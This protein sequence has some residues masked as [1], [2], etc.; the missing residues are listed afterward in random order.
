MNLLRIC[1]MSGKKVG[2]KMSHELLIEIAENFDEWL[3]EVSLK[4]DIDK[5]DLQEIIKQFLM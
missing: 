3:D 5:Q 2:Y 4:F 1:C